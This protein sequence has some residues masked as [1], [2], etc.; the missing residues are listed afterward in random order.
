MSNSDKKVKIEL[1]FTEDEAIYLITMFCCNFYQMQKENFE[2][3]FGNPEEFQNDD[4]MY[5]HENYLNA[6]IFKSYMEELG[7]KT[8]MLLYN[9]KNEDGDN[10]S[11]FVTIS[12]K[13]YGEY[14]GEE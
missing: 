3:L 13:P 12:N 1:S 10:E 9:L 11:Q 7:Y 5:Y 6:K 2:I 4:T 8:S 14:L